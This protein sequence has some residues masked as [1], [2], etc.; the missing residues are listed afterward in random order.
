MI[1]W[2]NFHFSSFDTNPRF[3]SFLLYVRW[4]SG[5]TFVR[6]CFRDENAVPMRK[7]VGF[8]VSFGEVSRMQDYFKSFLVV[9]WPHF[10]KSGIA[11][12]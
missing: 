4:I 10:R 3:P 12:I 1:L 6:R 7:S 8:Y 2:R 9:E 11:N 5:V